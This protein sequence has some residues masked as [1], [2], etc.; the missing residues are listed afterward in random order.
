M[1]NVGLRIL[2]VIGSIL[3]VMVSWHIR[4]FKA[5]NW[6]FHDILG[7]HRPGGDYFFDGAN[8]HAHCRICGKEIIQDSQGNWF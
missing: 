3:F 7:W 5:L 8:V 4:P 6:L 1:V 2:L